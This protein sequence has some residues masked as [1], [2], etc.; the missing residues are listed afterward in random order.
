[1]PFHAYTWKI[2]FFSAPILNSPYEYPARHWELDEN[3]QPTQ[4]VIE[5]R[6]DTRY[7]LPI[8]APTEAK[9]QA[10][11]AARIGF[12]EGSGFS[13]ADHA[14]RC[15]HARRDHLLVTGTA[16]ASEFLDDLGSR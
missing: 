10:R 11:S 3:G 2:A 7:I 4:R 1:L 6:R 14:V 13:T 9:I 5:T 12:G 15:L 16:P 8:P